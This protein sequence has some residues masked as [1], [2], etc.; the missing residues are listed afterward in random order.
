MNKHRT[1]ALLGVLTAITP[2]IGF[3]SSWEE[4]ILLVLGAILVV[5]AVLL[6]RERK[7]M[8]KQRDMEAEQLRKQSFVTGLSESNIDALVISPVHAQFSKEA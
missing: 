1:I 4:N 6:M 3:P 2:S 8:R 7:I 5:V